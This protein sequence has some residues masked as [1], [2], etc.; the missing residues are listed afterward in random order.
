[1][2]HLTTSVLLVKDTY[3]CY[4]FSPKIIGFGVFQEN[5]QSW[6]SNISLA[7][8]TR[9]ESRS[10]NIKKLEFFFFLNLIA[11]FQRYCFSG[12][13]YMWL[14]NSFPKIALSVFQNVVISKKGYESK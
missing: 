2:F 8:S 13:R 14:Q 4:V 6:N 12:A 11:T 1:M 7:S 10:G 9:P 3:I 5:Y